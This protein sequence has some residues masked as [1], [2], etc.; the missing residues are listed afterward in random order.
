M[1]WW[2]QGGSAVITWKM[3]RSHVRD[4]IFTCPVTHSYVPWLMDIWCGNSILLVALSLC[5][6]WL[7]SSTC[8]MT[9]SHATWLMDTGCGKSILL[10]ALSLCVPWLVSP[11]CA[12]TYSH[13]SW[14]Q[15]AARAHCWQHSQANCR[16]SK[17]PALWY[18]ALPHTATHGLCNTL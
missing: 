8:A 18:K 11:I 13:D 2:I 15:G 10:A 7:V 12:M 16:C 3:T 4:V 14:I 17:A 9:Y 5:V 1:C 6:P